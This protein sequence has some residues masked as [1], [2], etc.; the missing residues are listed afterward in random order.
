MGKKCYRAF[1]AL[2]SAVL[3]FSF[4]SMMAFALP[5]SG[6]E[7][8][9]GIDVSEWQGAID[10]SRVRQSGIQVVYIRY[11]LGSDYTDPYFRRNYEGAKAQGLKVGFYHYVTARTVAQAKQEAHFFAST[12]AGTQPDCRLA[13]D[14]EYLD[15]LSIAQINE[16]SL[17]FLQEL[18]RITGKELVL[19]SD[20]YNARVV[21]DRRLAEAYPLWVAQ[22]GVETP[23]DN[24]KWSSWVGFQYSSTGRVAGIRGNVDLNRFT[25]DIFLREASAAPKPPQPAP[26]KHTKIALVTVRPGDTLWGIARRYHTTVADL[27][28]LNRLQNP[29]LIYAGEIIRVRVPLREEPGVTITTY[30]VR[31]GDTLTSIARQFG[32]TVTSIVAI[33]DLKNPNLIYVGEKLRVRVIKPAADKTYTVRRG[34]TLWEIAQRFGTTVPALVRLNRLKNPDL[35]YVGDVLRIP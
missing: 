29:N 2:M 6:S 3:L 28:R 7:L 31:R 24:G 20:A 32:T 10:F 26:E 8:Y 21:F 16:I 11:S 25:T 19:Y 23:E 30:T 15:G 12:I 33:N 14:F 4:L 35:I 27:L 9:R 18:S 22:Y 17:A 13:M 5:P 1:C 34:D